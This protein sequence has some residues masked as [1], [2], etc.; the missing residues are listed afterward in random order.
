[1]LN[2]HWKDWCYS[3]NSDSLATL[4]EDLTHWKRPWCWE[5]SKAGG[6]GMAQVRCLDGI[7]DSM[8]MRLSKLWELVMDGEAWCAAVHGVTK[9]WTRL[10]DWT[11]LN[12]P[13]TCSTYWS[14][15]SSRKGWAP[16]PSIIIPR[17]HLQNSP[18]PSSPNS[19]QEKEAPK[20][21]SEL[22]WD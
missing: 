16:D 15:R 3:W 14:V 1:M 19:N 20:H 18:I 2:V 21:T 10:R 13:C 11:E 8:D 7:T 4:Y 17:N 6:E 5:R 12:W 9:S 22:F